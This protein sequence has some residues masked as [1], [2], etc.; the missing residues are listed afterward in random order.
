VRKNPLQIAGG[1]VKNASAWY[2]L[3]PQGEF[4]VQIGRFLETKKKRRKTYYKH[5]NAFKKKGE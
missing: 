4:S 5:L 3:L 2:A 1:V